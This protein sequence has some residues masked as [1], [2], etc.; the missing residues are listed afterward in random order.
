[1]TVPSASHDKLLVLDITGMSCDHCVARVRKAIDSMPG[2]NRSDVGIGR[3][4]VSYDSAVVTPERLVAAIVD[5][6]YGAELA[7]PDQTA[8]EEQQARERAQ[9]EEF[10]D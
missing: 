4:S 9:D 8:F 2:V 7:S 10:R 5:S 1:M 6:G 3:A